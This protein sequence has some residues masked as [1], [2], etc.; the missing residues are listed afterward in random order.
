[1]EYQTKLQQYTNISSSYI[2]NN[3]INKITLVYKSSFIYTTNSYMLWSN[4]WPSSGIQNTKARYIK[5][6]N[7]I[8]K[9]YNISEKLQRCIY[10]HMA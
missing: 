5:L 4:M 6:Q 8:T 9:I 7:K 2:Y 3:S 1:M 10:N